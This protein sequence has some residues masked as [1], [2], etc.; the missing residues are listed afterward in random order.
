MTQTSRKGWVLTA[1]QPFLRC[2]KKVREKMPTCWRRQAAVP[3]TLH[4]LLPFHRPRSQGR[5]PCST[6][7]DSLRV[8][9]ACGHRLA[10]LFILSAL[11]NS[12]FSHHPQFHSFPITG[13]HSNVFYV[14]P[15]SPTHCVFV[16]NIACSGTF[17]AWCLCIIIYINGIIVQ[18]SF[19]FSLSLMFFRSISVAL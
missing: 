15:S 5:L 9:R 12:P 16:R 8:W 2:S 11:Y 4:S 6:A 19:C 17:L 3:H 7:G 18:I 1:P 10:V 13:T 14:W